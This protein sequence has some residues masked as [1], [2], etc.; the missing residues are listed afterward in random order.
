MSLDGVDDHGRV[1]IA[2]A[3]QV[4]LD[5]WLSDTYPE[6]SRSRWQKAIRSGGVTVDGREVTPREKI[7][8]GQVLQFKEGLQLTG[9]TDAAK[10]KP[11]EILL[12]ILWEDDDILVISKAPGMV[13]H[14]GNGCESGTVVNAAL[15]HCGTLALLSDPTRPGIVHRLD[16]E[17]S[18]ALLVA[19]SEKA[20]QSLIQQFQDRVVKKTYLAVIQGLP[21]QA[22]GTCKGSIG[23]H[24][25]RRTRMAVVVGGKSAVSHWKILKQSVDNWSSVQVSIETGRTH[26][27]RA[28]MSDL[29]FPLLGDSVYGYRRNRSSGLALTAKRVLLHASEIEFMHPTN[30]QKLRILAPLP[31]DMQPFMELS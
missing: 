3:D 22:S 24:P 30:G 1:I 19:K 6:V 7:R 27:I 31:K 21:S 11:E 18:G 2:S 9:A 8:T 20:G 14:P 26:Q 29:G 12:E 10:P 15:H 17:T 13:V 25:V 23:R 4:R 5:R 28:H 16:K